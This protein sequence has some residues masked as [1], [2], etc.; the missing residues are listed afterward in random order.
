MSLTFDVP[1]KGI[2]G[3]TS[4]ADKKVVGKFIGVSFGVDPKGLKKMLQAMGRKILA[5]EFGVLQAMAQELADGSPVWTGYFVSNWDA[6][7]NRV[8]KWLTGPNIP[9]GSRKKPLKVSESEAVIMREKTANRL[10][11][12][13]EKALKAEQNFNHFQTKNTW[14]FTNNT[15]Y[16]DKVESKHGVVAG[17]KAIAHIAAGDALIEAGKV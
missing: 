11:K 2:R 13:L 10:I 12:R 16:A 3:I 4:Y 7:P 14:Y 1:L 5:A 9:W 6:T 17:A 8:S 15:P